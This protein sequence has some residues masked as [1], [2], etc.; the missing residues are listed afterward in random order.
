MEKYLAGLLLSIFAL[1]ANAQS[2]DR[3]KIIEGKFEC[4]KSEAA[5]E[6]LNKFQ[7]QPFV[8]GITFRDGG[9]YDML[10]FTNIETGSWTILENHDGYYCII[11]SGEKIGVNGEILKLP[12][13]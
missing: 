10:L 3:V 4:G 6:L 9:S 5:I 13:L 8:R 1:T 12:N 11:A 2:D 7:E